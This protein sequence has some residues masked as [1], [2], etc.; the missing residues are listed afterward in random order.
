MIDITDIL[1]SN[2]TLESIVTYSVAVLPTTPIA[3]VVTIFKSGSYSAVPIVDKEG[4]LLGQITEADLLLHLTSLSPNGHPSI[5]PL[6]QQTASDI[7]VPVPITLSSQLSVREALTHFHPINYPSLPVISGSGR[8]LGIVS[9]AQF[10]HRANR[11][12]RPPTLGGLA[13]PGGVYLTSGNLTGGVGWQ[14]LLLMGIGFCCLHL[15]TYFLTIPLLHITS[16]LPTIIRPSLEMLLQSSI[17]VGILLLVVRISPMAG[18]HAA[19][20]QVVHAIERGEPLTI[21]SVR[22]MPR[23]HPRCG[24]NLVGGALLA[25][26][27]GLIFQPIMGS[28][29]YLIGGAVALALW[30]DVGSWLQQHITTRPASNRELQSGLSAARD[31]LE[32]YERQG[33]RI[34]PPMTRLWNMGFLPL[35]T[36]FL[37]GCGI[38]WILSWWFPIFQEP[39]RTYLLG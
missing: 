20:H 31:I 39:L 33:E 37:L 18:Y 30:R 14:A 28:V 3:D 11:P 32:K 10:Y 24:T 25:S 13:T 12:M 36:G 9:P 19:E 21:D 7:M 17:Q 26:F 22:R 27:I 2:R 38:V 15:V 5:A 23:V 35:I 8:F 29:G 1:D 34:A 16:S 4:I 6:T